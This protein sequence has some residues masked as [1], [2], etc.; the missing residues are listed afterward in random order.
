MEYTLDKNNVSNI[1]MPDS[2]I[3]VY[4]VDYPNGNKFNVSSELQTLE[5][6]PNNIR[7]RSTFS[8]SEKDYDYIEDFSEGTLLDI[9]V[10]CWEN[11]NKMDIVDHPFIEGIIKRA[12]HNF[13]DAAK[14]DNDI[15]LFFDG[16][17]TN[18]FDKGL[19]IV[20][21]NDRITA[22][23]E[24]FNLILE[25]GKSSL[26][27]DLLFPINKELSDGDLVCEYYDLLSGEKIIFNALPEEGHMS[28]SETFK[29]IGIEKID[30]SEPIIDKILNVLEV[31]LA[32]SSYDDIIGEQKYNEY[33][34]SRKSLASEAIKTERKKAVTSKFSDIALI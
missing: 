9:L 12:L 14:K 29:F 18:K 28:S 13:I 11:P 10:E 23:F 1:H 26:F 7:L 19:G 22:T 3:I 4:G 8:F 24:S 30:F 21:Q 34:E 6:T 17:S 16:K 25:N 5:E 27:L 32:D 2:R 33:C 31:P 20:K 15:C